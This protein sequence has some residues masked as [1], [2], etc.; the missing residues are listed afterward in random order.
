MI[1]C[2]ETASPKGRHGALGPDVLGRH[3]VVGA[4]VWGEVPGIE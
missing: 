1:Q 2:G 4:A 3:M